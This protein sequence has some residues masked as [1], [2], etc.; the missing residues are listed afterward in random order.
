MKILLLLPPKLNEMK[1]DVGALMI[2]PHI[3]VAY[4]A[5]YLRSAGHAVSIADAVAECLNPHDIGNILSKT[6]PDIVGLSAMTDRIHDA[7]AIAELVKKNNPKIKTVV[8]GSH[9][10]ALP[11]ETL[12][13]FDSF[14]YAVFGEGEET[15]AEF[16]KALENNCDTSHIPGLAFR[17]GSKPEKGPARPR[18]ENLDTLP[19]PAFDLFKLDRY[20]AFYTRSASVRELPVSTARGCPFECAFCSKVMGERVVYRSV[21]NVV[22]EISY[23]H[24]RFGAIQFVM[25]DESFTLSLN[26][27]SVFCDLF[28]ERGLHK[29]INWIVHSRIE[30]TREI[31]MK[32]RKANCT[33]I[34][35]G[36][37]AGNQEILDKNAKKITLEKSMNAVK[38]AREAGMVTDGNFILGLPYENAGTIKDTIRFAVRCNPDYASFFLFVPYPGTRAMQLAK[39]GEANLK[40]LSTDWRNYGKQVGG[41]VE[42]KD[43]PRKRL[44]FLQF[45]AYLRFYL[46]P[47]KVRPVFNKIDFKTIIRFVLNLFRSTPGTSPNAER[48]VF[49]PVMNQVIINREREHFDN[50]TVNPLRFLKDDATPRKRAMIRFLLK[51][52]DGHLKYIPAENL[53]GKTVLDA[54]CGNPRIVSWMAKHGANAFGCD[55]SIKMLN[56]EDKREYSYALDEEVPITP[57]RRLLADCEKMPFGENTF[58]TITCFQ[59]LHHMDCTRFFQECDRVLKQGGTI[60]ISDPNGNHM[61]RRIANR[62]GRWIGL[63][64]RDENSYATEEIERHLTENNFSLK[65]KVSIN[66]FSEILFLIEETYRYSQPAL[67]SIVRASL[68]FFYPLDAFLDA[69]LFKLIPSLAWRNILIGIKN[70]NGDNSA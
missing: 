15:F 56:M 47:G 58:D 48:E 41:A 27:T 54:C 51:R 25:T 55:I 64:S 70:K 65:R 8:G 31:L 44:E 33:H 35:Y 21:K 30:V 43:V 26:R 38:W 57:E 10:S 32:M 69:T 5:A 53:D 22:D 18:I 6:K 61:L 39:A 37:E 66:I 9:P 20:L 7:A 24:E 16:V 62:F 49:E 28:M 42:L 36:L 45:A 23:H 67:S 50:L 4:I 59:A 68:F 19:T 63:L 12:A 29:Y 17:N 3:G 60:V 2:S 46:R 40:L 1:R 13:E 11:K 14:D 34:T 52:W